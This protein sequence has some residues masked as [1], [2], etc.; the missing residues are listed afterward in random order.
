[1]TR[2]YLQEKPVPQYLAGKNI[3][4]SFSGD[5]ASSTFVGE[6]KALLKNEFGC[7]CHIINK[8]EAW[9]P[10]WTRALV[11]CD[12]AICV[13]ND[14]YKS[15]KWC[16]AE[17]FLILATEKPCILE[18]CFP[19]AE[20]ALE[21]YK[22]SKWIFCGEHWET[23]ERMRGKL[24]NDRMDFT[25]EFDELQRAYEIELKQAGPLFT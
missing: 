2:R 20:E 22:T 18:A 10:E 7:K 1:M 9:K 15:S 16:L 8:S 3:L 25:K 13:F 5:T 19:D 11:Q 17:Y 23:E 4:F 14:A 24:K 6:L 21:S 12:F